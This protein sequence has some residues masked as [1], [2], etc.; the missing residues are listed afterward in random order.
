[1]TKVWQMS[2]INTETQFT[3]RGKRPRRPV[4]LLRGPILIVDDN[5]D[6]AKLTERVFLQLNS[7]LPITVLSSGFDLVAH[8]EKH[9]K[10]ASSVADS[11]DTA[12]FV[13]SAILLDM[14][15]PGMDGFSV[16]EWCAKQPKFAN[17]PVIVLTNFNDLPHMKQ[18][19]AL[20]ARSYLLKPI[21][22]NALRSVLSSLSISV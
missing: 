14:S 9:G 19:Y 4:T 3:V 8:L 1:M 11:A 16:L 6:D 17:I 21:D 22:Q 15:M 18:A 5:E 2:K 20:G 12:G 10:G 13:P 7:R